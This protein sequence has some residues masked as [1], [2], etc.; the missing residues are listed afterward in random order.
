MAALLAF[1][2]SQYEWVRVA[3]TMLFAAAVVLAI[4][5][6][7]GR[8]GVLSWSAGIPVYYAAVFIAFPMLSGDVEDHDAARALY[9]ASAGL[10]TF[11]L[12]TNA[13]RIF[14]GPSHR[15]D[16]AGL[17]RLDDRIVLPLIAIGAAAQAWSFAFGYFGLGGFDTPRGAEAGPVSALSFCLV[18]AHVLAWNAYFT[19]QRLLGAAVVTTLVLTAAGI[20]SN[21]K[22]QMLTP[23]ALI[24]LCQWG[25]GKFPLKLLG[26]AV[27]LYVFVAFPF[28][29]ASRLVQLTG[30]DGFSAIAVDYLLSGNWIED[31]AGESVVASFGRGL[32]PYFADI[33]S[34]AGRE[35][36]FMNG[37]T[38]VE[39]VEN[40][41]PRFLYADKADMSIANWT[42]RE[43]GV[44]DWQDDLTAVGPTYM[45]EFFM[46]FGFDGVCI[47]MALVGMLAV[48]VDRYVIVRRD[49]WT[50]PIV[51]SL[52][53]WQES[54]VGHT[55]LPFL[56]NALLWVAVL[57]VLT[58]ARSGR[59]TGT[60]TEP[61]PR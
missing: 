10:F 45:G 50:M 31:A 54:F 2:I 3:P 33:V 61:S 58:A 6:T 38:Y 1:S 60:S 53:G 57:I 42:A 41:I 7:P 20:V 12:G 43:F 22:G 23:L 28:V 49:A 34:K 16:M 44:I 14:D 48:L 13:M 21:S 18:I 5:L 27:I 40:M 24:A 46:N 39:G 4:A 15:Y 29:T 17:L 35:V 55:I 30:G 51:V 47:G 59:S 56:K 8:L 9:V 25:A 32:L 19:R 37:R 36:A 52:V 11:T 26:A